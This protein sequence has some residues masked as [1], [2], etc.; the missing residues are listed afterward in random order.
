MFCDL[1][2]KDPM[3]FIL[4]RPEGRQAWVPDSRSQILT[5]GHPLTVD[6][7]TWITAT[8]PAVGIPLSLDAVML[9][10]LPMALPPEAPLIG[11]PPLEAVGLPG[12]HGM[13]LSHVQQSLCYGLQ[14]MTAP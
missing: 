5:P 11:Q 8:E 3:W 6:P 7:I 2:R 12:T 10:V 14:R 1:E 9:E 13:N 4:V